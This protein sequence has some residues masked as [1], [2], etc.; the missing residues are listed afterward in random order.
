MSYV[1]EMLNPIDSHYEEQRDV[2]TAD[3][4][5]FL[6]I[7]H[8]KFEA[9]R[10]SLLEVRRQRQE[11]FDRGQF[12]ALSARDRVDP[13]IFLEGRAHSRGIA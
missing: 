12:P 4:C 11:L 3:A 7:L 10:V 9:R 5:R 1:V 8:Q 6:R 2:L 13:A